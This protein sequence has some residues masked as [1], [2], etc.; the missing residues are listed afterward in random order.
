MTPTLFTLALEDLFKKLN[1]KSTGVNINDE[2]LN[3]LQFTDD[4]AIIATSKEDV[5]DMLIELDKTTK[6]KGF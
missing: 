6:E 1:W 5:Q 4:I 3:H 2:H